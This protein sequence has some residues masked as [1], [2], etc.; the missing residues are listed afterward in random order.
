[1]T[2]AVVGYVLTVVFWAAFALWLVSA[3][4]RSR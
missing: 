2:Y 1:M 3:T 4:R